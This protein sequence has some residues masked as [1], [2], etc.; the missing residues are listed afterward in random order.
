MIK[1]QKKQLNRRSLARREQMQAM[2]L[3]LK[4]HDMAAG[5]IIRRISDKY[6]LGEAQV[7]NILQIEK[8]KLARR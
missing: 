2:Y 1:G 5:A 3:E 7:Y 6:F 4:G 8:N